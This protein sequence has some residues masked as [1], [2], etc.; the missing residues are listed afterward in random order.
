MGINLYGYFTGNHW[1]P[2][3]GIGPDWA[4]QVAAYYLGMRYLMHHNMELNLHG[5]FTE[6]WWFSGDGVGPD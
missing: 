1:F 5:Y 6:K 3:D 2:T 4:R